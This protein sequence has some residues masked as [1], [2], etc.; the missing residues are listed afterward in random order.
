MNMV[1]E[2]PTE[3]ER[4]Q[5]IKHGERVELFHDRI[6][7]VLDNSTCCLQSGRC[8]QRA[9]S[10]LVAPSVDDLVIVISI[11]DSLFITDIAARKSDAT[12]CIFPQKGGLTIK[13]EELTLV[14]ERMGRLQSGGD[15]ELSAPAGSLKVVANSIMQSLSG[16]FVVISKLFLSKSDVINLEANQTMVSKSKQHFISATEDIH[17]D[18]QRINMG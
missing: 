9:V 18:A 16:A 15:L 5:T 17:M 13:A 8:A 6:T 1:A 12:I 10:C 14:G 11:D 4:N 7:Q 2:H 3:H